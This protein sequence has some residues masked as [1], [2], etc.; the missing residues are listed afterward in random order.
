MHNF[1]GTLT[2]RRKREGNEKQ[3]VFGGK[4]ALHDKT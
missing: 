2:A 1:V 3:Q 4:Q